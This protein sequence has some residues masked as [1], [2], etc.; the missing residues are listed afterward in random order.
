MNKEQAIYYI[1]ISIIYYEVQYIHIEKFFLTIVFGTCKLRHYMLNHQTYVVV[2]NDP[3]RYM[4]SHAYINSRTSKWI[5]LLIEYDLEFVNQKSIKENNIVDQLSKSPL[6]DSQP[7]SLD[8][9]D[10]SIFFLIEDEEFV[11]T[12]DELDITLFFDGSKCEQGGGAGIV[13]ITPQGEPIP[14][15]FKFRLPC[16]NNMAEYEALI[17]G[18]QTVIKLNFKKIKIIGAS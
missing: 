17:L 3:L 14:L 12:K 5:M 2:R 9:P 6:N 16:T 8:F 7:L 15:S 1:N 18:L 4:M 11:D 13:F 10:Y